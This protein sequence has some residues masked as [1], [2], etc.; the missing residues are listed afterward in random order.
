M[1]RYEKA[2]SIALQRASRDLFFSC[3]YFLK[4]F[5]LLRS[6]SSICTPIYRKEEAREKE[7]EGKRRCAPII[8]IRHVSS[9]LFI[10]QKKKWDIHT[11][12]FV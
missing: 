8:T 1:G 7:S 2:D 9:P 10:Q 6:I 11:V 4:S 5:I 3:F 12:V